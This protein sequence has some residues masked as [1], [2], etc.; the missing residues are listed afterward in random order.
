MS[1]MTNAQVESILVEDIE[2]E[3]TEELTVEETV[4]ELVEALKDENVTAYGVWTVVMGAF[5]VLEIEKTVPSQMMY[6]YTRNGMIVKG[7]K[8]SAKDIRYTKD[9]VK[10]FAT[11]YVTKHAN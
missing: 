9:E 5:K 6:N 8:G 7:K 2:T 4:T 10:A 3:E 11:K 1:E